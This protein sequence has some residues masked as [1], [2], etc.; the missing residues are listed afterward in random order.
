MST[1]LKKQ[2]FQIEKQLMTPFI[3]FDQLNLQTPRKRTQLMA[4]F[5]KLHE[6]L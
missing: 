6:I 1:Y 3:Q 5:C 4:N 2:N